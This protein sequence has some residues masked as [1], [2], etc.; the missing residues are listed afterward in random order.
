MT[1]PDAPKPTVPPDPLTA[2]LTD[3][4]K[5]KEYWQAAERKEQMSDEDTRRLIEEGQRE[6]RKC[7]L[8]VLATW[9]SRLLQN[10]E[11]LRPKKLQESL[12]QLSEEAEE[13]WRHADDQKQFALVYDALRKACA[14]IDGHDT[15]LDRNKIVDAI[16][17][18]VEYVK[19]SLPPP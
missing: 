19:R 2:S 13:I 9:K 15:D 7:F 1:S 3:K 4:A 8:Q 6:G 10:A 11:D 12:N 16:T 5:W 18:L 14:A 17:V